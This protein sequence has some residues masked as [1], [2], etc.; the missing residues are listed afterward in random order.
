MSDRYLLADPPVT[1]VDEWLARGGGEG[2][3][4]AADLGPSQTIQ[5]LA[6]AGLRG[7]GGAGFPVARKWTGVREAGGTHRFVVCNAAEGEPA[8]FKDRAILRT[9]PYQVIEGLVVAAM[10]ME[11]HQAYI[12]IKASFEWE[13]DALALALA[14]M[15][16]AGLAGDVS[17]SIVAGPEEYLFGEEKALLEVIEGHAPLPRQLPPFEH[18]L[19]AT[20]PQTG[21]ESHESQAG[22]VGSHE[23]NPTLV[24]NA[25]TLATVPPILARGAEWFRSMGTEESPGNVVATVVGDVVHAGVDEVELGTP[26][27]AVIDQ[28]GGGPRPGQ[29]VKAV[30]PG[31]AN[32]VVTA[33]DLATPLTYEAFQAIGSGMG[34]AGFAVFDETAC[35]V[36]VA[37]Q[38][39]RFLWIESCGQCPPCKLGSEEVTAKLAAIEECRGTDRDLE[40][41]G[42]QLRRVTD[43]ARCYLATQEQVLVSSILRSFPEEFAAHLEGFCP[44][45][46]SDLVAA[47]I[48]DISDGRVLYDERQRLKRPDW[49]Y[50]D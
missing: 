25:E 46:R 6:R 21:W 11:A 47:K 49:T 10:A 2:L 9:N 22:H 12:G 13:R 14:E 35:M 5:E 19:F 24:N 40:V 23:S 34:A 3:A 28:V 18:G 45:P 32:P 29:A 39:S 41:I 33:K 27:A 42:S 37:H 26:L 1:S 8:T 31:A 20:A 48:V 15:Q 17:V 4:R 16:S 36:E 44:R 50:A 7:R 38:Y 30:L 43:A